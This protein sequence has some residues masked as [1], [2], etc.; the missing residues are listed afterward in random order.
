MPAPFVIFCA[1]PLNPRSVE[2][3][4][5][6]EAEAARNA[7]FSVVRL[8]HDYLDRQID[9]T[10][11]LKATRFDGAG[12]AV[13]RGW[14]M[15]AEAYEALY[16]ALLARSVRLSVS[17]QAYAACHHAPGSY[18][19]LSEWM[20]DTVWIDED[21]IDDWAAIRTTLEPFG[22]TSLIVKDWVK[23]QASG[24][25]SEACFIAD[26]ADTEAVQRTI[27]RFRN[28]QG[29][30]L[31]GGLVFKQ[32]VPLVPTG[33]PAYEYR[34]FVVDG[35]VAGCWPRSPESGTL[36]PPPAALLDEVAARIPSPFASAD[37]GRDEAGRWWLLEVGDGQVSGLPSAADAD[38]I[39]QALRSRM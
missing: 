7:G 21:Q 37:F 27:A 24:Y 34:A 22:H 2:P 23:S 18:F 29:D 1:D 9:P 39:F 14:M 32:Y 28:L 13:Y 16:L 8:D 11:S 26:A 36:A 15:S 12:E 35:R 10:L 20:P 31:I 6:I 30:G 5:A 38:P 17:P 4:Y 19:A 3:E 25:W 33:S